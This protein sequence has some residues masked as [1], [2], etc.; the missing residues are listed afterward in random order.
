MKC[1]C[2]SKKDMLVI[3]NHERENFANY[4]SMI[5]YWCSVC[6]R[7]VDYDNSSSFPALSS[8]K[9]WYEPETCKKAKKKTN[10]DKLNAKLKKLKKQGAAFSFTL[11]PDKKYTHEKIA[12]TV[13]EM[14]EAK[15]GIS[16][17]DHLVD[18]GWAIN[19]ADKVVKVY[20][21]K[22]IDGA[23]KLAANRQTEGDKYG[24]CSLGQLHNSIESWEKGVKCRMV[25]ISRL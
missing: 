7:L 11:N 4:S 5:V 8:A 16:L 2:K 9:D 21:S 6:G 25:D 23:V 3:A 18:E 15:E 17:R 24:P 13:L 14:I 20:L 1:K 22:G 19:F 10:L 12:G